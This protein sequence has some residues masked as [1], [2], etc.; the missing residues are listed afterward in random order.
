MRD[1][2]NLGVAKAWRRQG[3]ARLILRQ[4]ERLGEHLSLL[5][6]AGDTAEVLCVLCSQEVGPRVGVA[7]HGARQ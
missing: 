6:A 2:A 1:A 4:C 7:A 3:I 5:C